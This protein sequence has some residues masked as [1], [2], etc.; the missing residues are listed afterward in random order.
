MN[1]I[2]FFG[3]WGVI[4][5]LGV[6]LAAPLG[7]I[8]LELI[9]NALNTSISRKA[10]WLS[11]LLL[12]LGAMSGDFL[13]AL[14]ALTVG[15]EV[16]NSVFSNLWIKFFLFALNLVILGY[17]GLSTLFKKPIDQ[18]KSTNYSSYNNEAFKQ[19]KLTFLLRKYI[20]GLSIV[21]TS[22]WSYLWWTSAGTI[23]LFSDFSF[24]D[25]FS[26]LIIVIMF[27]TGIF[28]W[29]FSFS[30]ILAV[31]GKSPNQKFFTIVTKGSALILLVFALIILRDM[32]ITLGE[33]L[34]N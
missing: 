9:K 7:P 32:V 28:L 3:I 33:I 25:L 34:N 16:L 29:M 19:V 11:A 21:V 18:V 13:V 17:L 30:T 14:T 15:G 2:E 20:T 5:A 27:L 6:T 24:P 23:I 22:P 4:A 10:A 26:R 1:L 12:G 8:N 31:V